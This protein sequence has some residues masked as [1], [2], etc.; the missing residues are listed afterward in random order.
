MLTGEKP[1]SA[2]TTAGLLE[3]IRKADGPNLVETVPPQVVPVF[4]RA[5]AR[6]PSSRP[7]SARIFA[8]ELGQPSTLVL[9]LEGT[10][11]G[12]L[13]APPL[14]FEGSPDAATVVMPAAAKHSK[15]VTG[16]IAPEPVATGPSR[17]T[18]AVAG[19]LL[20]L[21]VI[22]T[23]AMAGDSPEANE[24][25]VPGSTTDS[26]T[27][28]SS[29]LPATTT[30]TTSTTSTEATPTL[31]AAE[32][33]DLLADL[34]PP[35]YKPKDVKEVDDRVIKAIDQWEKGQREMATKSLEDAFTSLG[36]L[37][38]SEAT[39]DLFALLVTLAEAMGFDVEDQD[40][41]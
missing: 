20:L 39:E 3:V 32:I 31:L 23:L 25:G 16:N 17:R 40:D 30:S 8:T 2:D 11:S 9:P 29:T 19:G 6:D 27:T 22:A 13:P 18:V 15:S 28:T 10:D 26:P 35:R 37:P 12:R 38:E 36:R 14:G 21:V 34:E 7:I 33:S 5:M 1:Y 41:D 24:Q 4:A